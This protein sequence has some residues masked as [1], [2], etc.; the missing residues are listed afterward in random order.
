MTC[1]NKQAIRL[2]KV[3]VRLLKTSYKNL[4]P[5]EYKLIKLIEQEEQCQRDKNSFWRS[6][7]RNS[8]GVATVEDNDWDF[9]QYVDKLHKSTF[10]KIDNLM[11]KWKWSDAD[12]LNIKGS[13]MQNNIRS[14]SF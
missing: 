12:V 9:F 10:K 3:R 4:K 2:E 1:L 5:Q 13:H 11:I 8:D 6:V 14:V 7:V